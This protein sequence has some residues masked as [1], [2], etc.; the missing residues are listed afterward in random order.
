MQQNINKYA[1]LFI[2][3]ANKYTP[4]HVSKF[5]LMSLLVE[6]HTGNK[7]PLFEKRL[8]LEKDKNQYLVNI[9]RTCLEHLDLN[10]E[11]FQWLENKQ[12]QN[13]NS[14]Y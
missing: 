3:W 8:Q 10:E 6:Y 5:V 4:D 11:Y 9:F 7:E 12:Q 2:E 14:T 13:I 1:K